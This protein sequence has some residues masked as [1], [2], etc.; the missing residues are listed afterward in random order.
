[1]LERFFF[2]IAQYKWLVLVYA[3]FACLFCG[4]IYLKTRKFN[5]DKKTIAAFGILYNLD[6]RSRN[7]FALALGRMALIF[8]F[9]ISKGCNDI[10]EVIMLE[11]LTLFIVLFS[12]VW[13]A[14]VQ[15]F[16]FGALFVVLFLE[17]VFFDYYENMGDETI[18]LIVAISFGV[19]AFLYSLLQLFSFMEQLQKKS[20]DR[21]MAKYN[22]KE[23]NQS[24]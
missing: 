19:F 14:L 24:S 2:Q 1:M 21:D 13:K 22:K 8:Y 6:K 16:T 10:A 3:V 17:Y 7:A 11:V 5:W 23:S 9:A 18:V 15:L 20:F 4:V 12:G